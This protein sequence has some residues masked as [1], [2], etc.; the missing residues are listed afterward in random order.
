MR[1]PTSAQVWLYAVTRNP[2]PLFDVFCW[3]ARTARAPSGYGLRST[4]VITAWDLIPFRIEGGVLQV[5]RVSLTGRRL[6]RQA[7]LRLIGR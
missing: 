6:A 5:I 7:A 1:A 3:N 4:A 2:R